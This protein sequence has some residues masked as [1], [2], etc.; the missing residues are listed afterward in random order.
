M[1]QYCLEFTFTREAIAMVSEKKVGNKKTFL[2]LIFEKWI[3]YHKIRE[4]KVEFTLGKKNKIPNF[5]MKEW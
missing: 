5:F 1:F 2:V 4:K 3:I